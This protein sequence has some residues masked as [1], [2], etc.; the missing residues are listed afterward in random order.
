MRNLLRVDGFAS[1]GLK[2]KGNSRLARLNAKLP[3]RGHEFLLR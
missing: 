1:A 3:E 2:G